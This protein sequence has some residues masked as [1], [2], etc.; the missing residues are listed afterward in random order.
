[1][2]KPER[3]GQKDP[4][5]D[6]GDNGKSNQA[7]HN[8]KKPNYV[9]SVE[10]SKKRGVGKN[11]RRTAAR[12]STS[13]VHRAKEATATDRSRGQSKEARRGTRRG[14]SGAETRKKAA[15]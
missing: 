1:M 4:R 8:R 7:A 6:A 12:T 15:R 9:K 5:L 2:P 13:G 14:C 10:R 11:T 3:E